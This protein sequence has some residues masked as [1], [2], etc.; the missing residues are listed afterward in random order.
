MHAPRHQR[1]GGEWYPAKLQG[2]EQVKVEKVKE[3][4]V[5][6]SARAATYGRAAWILVLG[7][8][9]VQ[10]TCSLVVG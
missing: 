4:M 7:G 10:A 9:D 5:H 3:S 1:P 8:D 6:W 2:G